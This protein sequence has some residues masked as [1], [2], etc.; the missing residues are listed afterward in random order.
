MNYIKFV[1]FVFLG[2]LP[3]N[4]MGLNETIASYP[5]ELENIVSKIEQMPEVQPLL[6]KV[7]EKGPIAL[8]LASNSGD[9]DAMWAS[10]RR[11]ILINP[12][13]HRSESTMIVSL[14]FELHNA[15]RDT[16]L[17]DLV[18]NAS[19]GAIDKDT[20]VYRTEKLEHENCLDTIRLINLGVKRGLF[21]SNTSW[22]IYADFEDHYK[23]QQLKGHSTW[24]A[25]TYNR[26]NPNGYTMVYKGTIDCFGQLSS[27][28][29]SNLERYLALK[30]NQDSLTTEFVGL[31]LLK[32]TMEHSNH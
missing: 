23:I 25:D 14:I 11:V 21:P 6:N 32:P 22:N 15:A 17:L 27:K 12:N 10:G 3:L 26:Y 31:A 4:L 19:S 20:F 29:K 30:N 18:D 5:P 24:L 1:L 16:E 2:S 28:E 7:Y 13:R 9:F 8:E